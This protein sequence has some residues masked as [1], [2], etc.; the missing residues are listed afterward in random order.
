M[1]ITILKY[2][3]LSNIFWA[4]LVHTTVHILNRGMLRSN[5]DK[6]P[7]EL[8]KG[9][10]TNVNHFRV[11]GRTCYI[12]REYNMI[13]KVDSQFDKGILVGY[14]R[15]IKAYKCYKLILKRIVENIN[16]NI[17]ETNVSKTIEKRRNSKEN[18]ANEEEVE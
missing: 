5:C 1:A 11:I 15:K 7:Y 6:T 8:S 2:F 10:L 17:D 13:G 16:V 3:K 14:S 4:Q 9:I 12:K 18:E